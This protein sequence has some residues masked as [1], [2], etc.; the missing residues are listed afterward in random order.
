M[1]VVNLSTKEEG[2]KNLQ[3]PANV[4]YGCPNMTF[5][6]AM[7]DKMRLFSE[8]KNVILTENFSSSSILR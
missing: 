6:K 2:N 5:S 7:Y 1:Y 4:V 3:K 8:Q